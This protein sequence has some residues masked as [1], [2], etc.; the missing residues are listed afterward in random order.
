MPNPRSTA[1]SSYEANSLKTCARGVKRRDMGK[2]HNIGS[3]LDDVD[4]TACHPH[5]QV[6]FEPIQIG[7]VVAPNRFYQVPHASGMTESNPRVRAALRETK[8]EGGWG[9]VIVGHRDANDALYQS[10]SDASGNGNRSS[11]TLIGDAL[12]PGAIVHAVYIGHLY[13]RRL[14]DPDTTHLRDEPVTLQEPDSVFPAY[15]ADSGS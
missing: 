2:P 1:Q 6:L 10:L 3:T 5:H 15:Q 4:L 9:V 7:P 11:V 8:A 14:I 12:A 13:S